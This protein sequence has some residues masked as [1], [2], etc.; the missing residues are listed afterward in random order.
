MTGQKMSLETVRA[1]YPDWKIGLSGHGY[2]T[3][4]LTTAPTDKR[5]PR[6]T[7]STLG[8][9]AAALNDYLAGDGTPGRCGKVKCGRGHRYGLGPRCRPL[10]QR[11]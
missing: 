10:W 2:W 1:A 6:I 9:L 7:G 3:A 5:A 8:E 11:P 4:W